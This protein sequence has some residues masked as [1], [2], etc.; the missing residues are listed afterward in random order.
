MGD[1]KAKKEMVK[2]LASTWGKRQFRKMSRLLV[3]WLILVLAIFLAANIS[4]LG[5]SYDSWQALLVAALMLGI[6][7]A[8]VRP[9]LLLLSLPFIL[10]TLGFFVVVINALLFYFVGWLVSGFHV[11]S[12]WSALGGSLIVSVVNMFLSGSKRVSTAARSQEPPRKPPEGKGP[13]ID[14]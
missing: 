13:V 14:I 3:R 5:I 8:L 12:F 7:N 4:F 1:G 9:I 2:P 11:E 10:V 6:V